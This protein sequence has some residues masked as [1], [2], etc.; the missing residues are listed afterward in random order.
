MLCN[1]CAINANP[2]GLN[3]HLQMV[4]VEH[5]GKLIG[6]PGIA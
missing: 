4:S 5:H 6:Q 2:T 1:L 3:G